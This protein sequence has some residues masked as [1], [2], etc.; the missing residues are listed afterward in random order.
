MIHQVPLVHRAP[1]RDDDAAGPR[2]LLPRVLGA[3]GLGL[4]PARLL[5][6]RGRGILLTL[7][8]CTVQYSTVQYN[9]VQYNTVQYRT[10]QHSTVQ[11]NTVQY[12]TVQYSTV[13]YSTIQYITV[14]YNTVQYSTHLAAR[15]EPPH[16]HVVNEGH[17]V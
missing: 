12:I 16:V 7:Q 17:V 13:Q 3:G 1:V 11:Y 14:Q 8:V 5:A 10:V 2:G 4:E 6:V 15:G 9:T